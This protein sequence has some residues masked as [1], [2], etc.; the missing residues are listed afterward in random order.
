MSLLGCSW[1]IGLHPALRTMTHIAVLPIRS[2]CFFRNGKDVYRDKYMQHFVY[3]PIIFFTPV[4]DK[5]IGA[6]SRSSDGG[7]TCLAS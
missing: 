7:E 5:L 6:L 1:R 3:H 2:F 4:I